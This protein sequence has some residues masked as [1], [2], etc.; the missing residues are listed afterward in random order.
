MPL[1]A[2]LVFFR[3][4]YALQYISTI[5]KLVVHIN[6][7]REG[8]VH[9]Y[10]GDVWGQVKDV[11]VEIQGHCVQCGNCCMDKRCM[12]LELAPGDK[13]LCGIYHSPFRRWS[14]CGSFP[15]NK[16]DIERYACPSYVAVEAVPLQ[17][18]PRH[19]YGPK[20]G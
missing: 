19:V 15:L 5:K 8:P 11:P 7:L 9:H 10:F 4:K 1:F 2:S 14:N 18:V 6:A 13:Y 12:F 16:H 17:F 20:I 3:K